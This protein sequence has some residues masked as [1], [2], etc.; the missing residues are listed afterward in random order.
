MA[1]SSVTTRGQTVSSMRS[2]SY[3]LINTSCSRF[4]SPIPEV[5]SDLE[6]LSTLHRF[7]QRWPFP[8]LLSNLLAMDCLPCENL[9]H[10]VGDRRGN[11]RLR[12]CTFR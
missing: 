1:I 5:S 12:T 4:L 8:G 10:G 11:K 9:L 7:S 3:F 6:N 2:S